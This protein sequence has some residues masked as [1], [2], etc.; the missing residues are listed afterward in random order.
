MRKNLLVSGFAALVALAMAAPVAA[1]NTT[2]SGDGSEEVGDGVVTLTLSASTNRKASRYQCT[3]P[4]GISTLISVEV[5]DCCIAGDN[6]RATIAKGT[7]QKTFGHTTNLAGTGPGAAVL[8]PNVFSTAATIATKV[9]KV[10]IL[11]T[12]GNNV[13][14]GLP[15]DFFVRISTN[16]GGPACALKQNIN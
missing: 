7:K 8:A 1:Q 11:A 13:P 14:G 3:D 12:A 16:G 5:A 15:A 4:T 9:K 2:G 6:W 10:D